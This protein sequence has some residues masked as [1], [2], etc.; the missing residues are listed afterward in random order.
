[1]PTG[2]P[3]IALNLFMATASA[4]GLALLLGATPAMAK[5]S[6]LVMPLPLLVPGLLRLF[7]RHG[8]P[9]AVRPSKKIRFVY[10][11]GGIIVYLLTLKLA[12]V[13]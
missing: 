5:Y 12:G 7:G 9:G 10:R 4:A 2:L 1:M 8:D 11:V 13:L 6:F 3:G